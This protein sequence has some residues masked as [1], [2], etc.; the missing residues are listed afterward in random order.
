MIDYLG[1]VGSALKRADPASLEKLYESQRLEVI[2]HPEERIAAVTI[3]P[4]RGS[5]RV[6][7]GLAR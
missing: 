6:R 1:D 7:G 4:G 5:E 2:Y 3:R